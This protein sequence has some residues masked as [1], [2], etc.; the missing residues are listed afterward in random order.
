MLEFWQFTKTK[1]HDKELLVYDE[2]VFALN[3]HF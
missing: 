2:V 3:G 1:L